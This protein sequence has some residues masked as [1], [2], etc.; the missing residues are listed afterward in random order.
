MAR[1]KKKSKKRK[2]FA[3]I[4][5]IVFLVG[6]FYLFGK[7]CSKFKIALNAFSSAMVNRGLLKEAEK[8]LSDYDYIICYDTM[9]IAWVN[10]ETVKLIGYT[11]KEALE[12]RN[13]DLVKGSSR[14]TILS[15]VLR[16]I[17]EKEGG[18]E[19]VI[20]T[21]DK[22]NLKVSLVYHTFSYKKGVYAVGK[23][24]N[25]KFISD[26]ETTEYFSND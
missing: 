26:E 14:E 23:I 19:I 20:R 9:R 22:R 15:R 6:A 7:P 5:I 18:S 24:V 12:L 4:A 21:K 2:I 3:V 25:Y 17:V 16:N 13:F 10:L 8:H 11:P 1:K